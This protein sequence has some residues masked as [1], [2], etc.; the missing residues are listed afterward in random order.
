MGKIAKT[1][2]FKFTHVI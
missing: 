1:S 2:L